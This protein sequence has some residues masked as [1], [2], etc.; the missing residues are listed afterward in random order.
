MIDFDVSLRAPPVL[1]RVS[2]YMG[3]RP[4][5][6]VVREP[7]LIRNEPPWVRNCKGLPQMNF[8]GK[9]ASR[10]LSWKHSGAFLQGVRVTCGELITPQTRRDTSE[11]TKSGE[12]NG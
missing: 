11:V 4:A 7:H 8:C 9:K 6:R 10:F 2:I 12:A 5:I 3:V 1:L